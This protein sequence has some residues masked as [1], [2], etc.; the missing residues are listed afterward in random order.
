MKKITLVIVVSMALACVFWP[1]PPVPAGSGP[2]EAREL[3][4]VTYLPLVRIGSDT[5][6]EWL[7]IVPDPVL[8]RALN[9]S[10]EI[11]GNYGNVVGGVVTRVTTASFYGVRAYR[12]VTGAN[13]DGGEFTLDTLAN[14]IH[15]IT[16][17]V[18][19]TLPPGWDWSLDDGVYTT[20]ELLKTYDANWSLYGLQVPAVQAVGSTTLFVRQGAAGAGDFNIDGIQVEEKEYWTSFCDGDQEGCEWL[21]APHASISQRSAQ[22]RAGGRVQDLQDDYHLDIGQFISTGMPPLDLAVDSYAI[23]PGGELGG[24]KVQSRVFTLTGVIRGTSVAN[25]HANRQALLD[26]LKPGAVP[27]DQPVRIRYTGAA[28]VKEIAAHYEGGLETSITAEMECWERVAIRFLADDPFWYGI[29]NDAIEL[30]SEDGATLRYITGRLR[31]TGQWDDLGLTADPTAAGTVYAIA[32]GPD[33]R[34]Y[35]GGNFTN[36]NNAGTGMDNIA[37]YDPVAD[38]WGPV[39]PANAV[40]D[41]VYALVFAPSGDLYAG[42]DFAALGGAGGDRVA[43]WDGANWNIV[44][45]GGIG[46]VKSLALGLDGTLYVGGSFVTWDGGDADQSF[47]TS[48]PIGGPWTALD[49]GADAIV[50]G[51]AVAPDGVLYAT[52]N[53]LNPETRI[54]SWDGTAWAALGTGI[55]SIGS[56]LAIDGAGIVYVT[57]AFTTADGVACNRIAMWNGVTFFPLGTGLGQ[58]GYCL[59]LAP[60]GMVYVGGLFEEAGG[61]TLTDR[62][63][64]WNGSSWAHLDVD[65]PGAGSVRSITTGP[66]APTVATNYDIFLGFTRTGATVFAGDVTPTNDGTQQAYPKITVSRTGGTSAII[67]EL[68]NETTGRELLF[69]YSLLDGETLTIDLSP[70]EKSIVSSFFGPRPAAILPNSDFGTFV[71]QPG[72]NLVTCFVA[73]DATVEAFLV[74]KDTYWSND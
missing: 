4:R 32:V 34:I 28:V 30:D 70:T 43:Y 13:N 29:G 64:K 38:T 54:A 20:P 42:G 65:L 50:Y 62:A 17:R 41:V 59:A 46:S 27:G 10:A 67:E 40:S 15:Y 2:A 68:R 8:N 11:A 73:T 71:L 19:G 66:P 51:M 18:R 72:G 69:D 53:F 7:V 49:V 6:G 5:M 56:A 60:D 63:A 16:M 58:Q 23:L 44:A 61:I 57:G 3:D 52:G 9:P 22:S 24:I 36:L 48:Y 21:G 74:F 14:E 26:V 25:L 45:A 35:I 55:N 31:A 33:Q 37:V 12:L 1:A 39:G 47:I